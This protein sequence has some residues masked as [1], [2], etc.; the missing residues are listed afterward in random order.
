MIIGTSPNGVFTVDIETKEVSWLRKG[1]FFGIASINNLCTCVGFA[2]N[3]AKERQ[4]EAVT[5][6]GD[7]I[8]LAERTNKGTRLHEYTYK[9]DDTLSIINRFS[10]YT[11]YLTYLVEDVHQIAVTKNMFY[12]SILLTNTKYNNIRL[13]KESGYEFE[14]LGSKK[15]N[16]SEDIN[17]INALYIPPYDDSMSEWY[18]G[19]NNKGARESEVIKNGDEVI[20][21]KGVYHSH[22]L[23]PYR[24]DILISASHQ[25]FVYSL[26]KKEPLFYT[27]D[28]WTRGICISNEGIWVGFSAVSPRSS[29]Q[30]P[31]LKN[32]INLF[33]HDKFELVK[34]IEVP[35]A[36]QIND[37]IYIDNGR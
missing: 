9:Y 17:H 28:V 19:L 21:L 5:R 25:G 7:S 32:S 1:S 33:S 26:N 31:N 34:S 16:C 30:D 27:G 29:R 10:N 15:S 2:G 36:G 24:G 18:V 37:I 13:I 4:E 6:V 11:S 22:D 23:E 8:Y 3:K 35:K 14:V 12:R 20:V